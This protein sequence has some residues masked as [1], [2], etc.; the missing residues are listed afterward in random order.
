MNW[1]YVD[2]GQQAGPVDDARLAELVASGKIQPA[3]LVWHEGMTGW[4]PYRDVVQAASGVATPPPPQTNI[5]STI[6]SGQVA[7]SECGRI[8]P[9][10]EVIRYEDKFICAGCKPIFFQRLSEGATFVPSGQSATATEADLLA[11]DYEVDIGGALSR[12]WEVFKSNAGGLIGVLIVV[13]AVIFGVAMVAY[14]A[15]AITG[16]PFVNFLLNFVTVLINA[17]LLAGL[18]LFYVKKVRNQ[19]AVI[20]DAFSTFGPRYWQLVLTQFIPM[21]ISMGVMAVLGVM[22]ALIVPGIARGARSGAFQNVAPALLIPLIAAA[23]VAFVVLMYLTTCWLFALPLAAD[24]GLKFWPAL[25]LS[26]RIVNKHW[27][28]TFWLIVVAGVVGIVGVIFCCI[29]LVATLPL[30]FLMLAVH[31]NK[32]FGDLISSSG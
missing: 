26:R 1:Y 29:G 30:T 11:R 9:S 15:V 10:N 31:Y 3:T 28:M 20:S 22:V 18:W 8:F 23:V 12:S 19:P 5:P 2:A 21:L 24:K 25:E 32:V 6:A 27:W 16:I 17:P 13:Y 14:A 7:C 4:L